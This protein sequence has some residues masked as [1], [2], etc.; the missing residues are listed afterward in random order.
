VTA[1]ELHV[2]KDADDLARGA[3]DMIASELGW[4]VQRQGRASFAVSGGTTPWRMF[5]ALSRHPVNWQNVHI[6]QVDE[7]AVPEDDDARSLRH[8]RESLL[9]HIDIPDANVHPIP[10]GPDLDAT[11]RDYASAVQRV[12]DGVLDL[13]HLGLGADGHTASLV[14]GDPV[15]SVDDRLVAATGGEYQGTRRVTLT[16]P[17]LAAARRIL[18]VVDGAGKADA[19]RRLV[20]GDDAIPAGHVPQDRAVVHCDE[21]AVSA[22]LGGK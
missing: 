22:L 4:F 15:L 1:L 9:D 18:W 3:A 5:A 20:A 16:Y 6:F 10:I 12:T 21:P 7:R 11:A 8:L 19:L 14:P 17:A 2:H 13:V